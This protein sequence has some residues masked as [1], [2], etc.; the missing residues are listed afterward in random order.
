M[1]NVT[2]N[3]IKKFQDL[4]KNLHGIE[5]HKDEVIETAKSLL[6]LKRAMVFPDLSK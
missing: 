3:D 4:C 2:I 6:L 1:L 5:L